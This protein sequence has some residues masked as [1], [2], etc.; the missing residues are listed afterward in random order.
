MYATATIT[1][2]IG[3]DP[4]IFVTQ[5]GLKIMSFGLP[6]SNSNKETGWIQVK[7]FGKQ[8]DYLEGKLRKGMPVS[9]SGKLNPMFYI[10]KD[11]V[12]KSGWELHL[13]P[14]CLQYPSERTQDQSL[15]AQNERP[16][17]APKK[18]FD[19]YSRPEIDDIPF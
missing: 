15:P 16:P 3:Q 13:Q 11:G 9:A 4:K 1:G 8:V 7:V 19:D 17:Q 10:G 12:Q 2:H 18:K 14:F 5:S 6:V